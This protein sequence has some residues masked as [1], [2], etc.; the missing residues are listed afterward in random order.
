MV[1]G[2]V[3]V[4]DWSFEEAVLELA[5]SCDDLAW[6]LRVAVLYSKECVL[7]DDLLAELVSPVWLVSLLDV[8]VDDCAR[9]PE[10]SSSAPTSPVSRIGDGGRVSCTYTAVMFLIK[11]R[12]CRRAAGICGCR[13]LVEEPGAAASTWSVHGARRSWATDPTMRGARGRTT[14]PLAARPWASWC[15]YPHSRPYACPSRV[16][17]PPCVAVGRRRRRS[18][19]GSCP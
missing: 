13:C 2:L 8:V 18:R 3:W 14:R 16:R 15:W 7:E 9:I 11:A 17:R 5:R 1:L 12:A 10:A 19:A 4:K 6:E